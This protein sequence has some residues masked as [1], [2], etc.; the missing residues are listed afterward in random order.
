MEFRAPT[1]EVSAELGKHAPSGATKLFRTVRCKCGVIVSKS[2]QEEFD[3]LLPFHI[4]KSA[5]ENLYLDTVNSATELAALPSGSI[6][7]NEK[8]KSFSQDTKDGAPDNDE[9]IFAMY[10]P[11]K[12]LI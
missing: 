6:V 3:K 10:G 1:T 12:V 7:I 8:G 9:D 2:G 11:F 5:W 4:A